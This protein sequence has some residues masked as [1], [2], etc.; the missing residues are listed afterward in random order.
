VPKGLLSSLQGIL[1]QRITKA[2][3]KN[4]TVIATRGQFCPLGEHPNVLKKITDVVKALK[5]QE[6]QQ[7]IFLISWYL[8][9]SRFESFE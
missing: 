4:H 6:T 2:Y 3:Y 8:R 1:L 5:L 7:T 9:R